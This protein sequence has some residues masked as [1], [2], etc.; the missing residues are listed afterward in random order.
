MVTFAAHTVPAPL[1]AAANTHESASECFSG[2]RSKPGPGT[3][4]S[5]NAWELMPSSAPET[6]ISGSCCISTPA[7]PLVTGTT[8]RG[9][10]SHLSEFSSS[11]ES[12]CPQPALYFP[13]CFLFTPLFL[14]PYSLEHL[15]GKLRVWASQVAESALGEPSLG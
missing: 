8:L 5:V 14:H 1:P 11:I 2:R 3:G 12:H 4:Q 15:P 13:S 7:S 6:T 10:L 9:T